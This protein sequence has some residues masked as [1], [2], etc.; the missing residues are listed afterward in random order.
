MAE[1][2]Y[3]PWCWQFIFQCLIN[4]LHEIAMHKSHTSPLLMSKY[5]WLIW[6]LMLELF[7]IQH[8]FQCII[9]W[10]SLTFTVYFG[11]IALRL[12]GFFVIIDWGFGVGVVA[13]ARHFRMSNAS[14]IRCWIYQSNK[15]NLC[16]FSAMKAFCLSN[17][18]W[19]TI[20]SRVEFTICMTFTDLIPTYLVYEGKYICSQRNAVWIP[21]ALS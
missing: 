13:V 6:Y 7:I 14:A 11:Q 2:P 17:D 12:H 10:T 4:K 21:F 15:Q 8:Q 1:L 3:L 20:F 9:Q 16:S 18:G 19:S 5:F